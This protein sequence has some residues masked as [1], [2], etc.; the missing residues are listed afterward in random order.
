[1]EDVAKVVEACACPVVSKYR[2][3][4]APTPLAYGRIGVIEQFLQGL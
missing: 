4:A 3:D 2:E 1:M